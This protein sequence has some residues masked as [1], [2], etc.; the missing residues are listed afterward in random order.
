MILAII[1]AGIDLSEESTYLISV[2]V[3]WPDPS[4]SNI[5]NAY[6]SLS[7]LNSFFC[8]IAATTNSEYSMYPEWSVST[9]SNISSIYFLE[10]CWP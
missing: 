8:S 1:S 10:I 7:V 9:A 6:V 3:I 4:L 5:L 2:G